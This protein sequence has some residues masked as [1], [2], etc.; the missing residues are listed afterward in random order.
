[1]NDQADN[2]P[3]YLE[4][5]QGYDNMITLFG[6]KPVLEVLRSAD[7]DIHRLHLATTNKSAPIIRELVALAS[8]RRIEICHHNRLELSRISKNARQDQGVALDIVAPNYQPLS[9]LAAEN[10]KPG[11]ELLLL[12]RI[13]NPQNLG[14]IIRTVAAAPVGGMILPKAGC[15]RLD[16]LVFKA[17][18]GTLFKASIYHCK[19]AS[20]AI[21]QLKH[22]GMDVCGLDAGAARPLASLKDKRPRV[23]VIGNESQGVSPEVRLACDH[24]VKIPMANQVESL[25]VAA[26]AALVAFRRVL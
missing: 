7:I 4:K 3:G 15:A 17:S 24:L 1:M 8:S 13:T 23:L 22:M 25:N 11:F 2:S 5:R 14:M 18:A 19:N 16:P 26:V 20:S 21:R 6:R 12:D 10:I 9:N